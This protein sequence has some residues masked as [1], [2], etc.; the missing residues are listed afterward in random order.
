MM[1]RLEPKNGGDQMIWGNNSVQISHIAGSIIQIAYGANTRLV[2]L[3]PAVVAIGSNVS[4][5]GRVL[6]ARAGVVPYTAHR[7]LLQD[8]VAWCHNG[9]AYAACV[10]GG[11]GGAGKTRLGVEL[12]SRVA[13]ARWL[14]GLLTAAADREELE[15]L[16]RVPTC[17]LVVVDYAET[18]IET[19]ASLLPLLRAH[20]SKEH[21]VRV[22]LLV[23]A[24]PRR[25]D[26][27][28][29]DALRGQ[30]EA[31]EVL[32]DEMYTRV[33]PDE[34]FGTDERS[35]L[36][37]AVVAAL[38]PRL[39]TGKLPDP[40]EGLA[41]PLFCSPLLVAASAYLSLVDPDTWPSTQA[42][43]LEDLIRHE[44]K[45]WSTT[46]P[47][48]PRDP[49]LRRRV[50]A[51]ATLTGAKSQDEA[52]KLLALVPNLGPN[53]S[54][55]RCYELAAWAHSLYPGPAYWNPVEPD[56]LGEHLVASTYEAQPG[57]LAGV[58]G[59][60][61][62]PNLVRPLQV[63]ARLAADR[64]GFAESLAALVNE[65]LP[66]LCRQ[67]I[68]EAGQESDVSVVVGTASLASVVLRL[69]IVVPP[70]PQRLSAVVDL[71]PRRPDLMLGPLAAALTERLVVWRRRLA[72]TNPDAYLPHLATSLNNLSLRLRDVGRREEGL[73]AIREAVEACRA[74][75]EANPAAY[76]PDLARSL[77]NLSVHLGDARRWEE[78]VATSQEAMELYRALAEA[79]PAAYFPDRA[80]AMNNMSVHLGKAG[81]SEEALAAIEEAVELRRSLAE[82]NPAAYLPDLATSLNNLSHRLG[83]VGRRE[84]GLAASQ[85]VME[86]YR[87]LAEA[88]PA[89]YLPD[90]AMSLNN[91]SNNLADV[92]RSEEALAAI[93][94]AVELRRALAE[95]N[96]AAYLPDLA[97]SLNNLSLR[98][99]DAG[100]QEEGVAAIQE[101]IELY[102][103][104]AEANPAAYLPDRAMSLN[105]LSKNLA[106]AGR[107][108]EGVAAIQ[109][110]I[111]LY[112]A[113]AE[114]NPAANFADRAMALN[115]LS[116]HLGNAGRWEEALAAAGEAVE[117]YRALAEANPAAY[118]Y[119]L[120]RSLNNLSVS[121]ADAGRPREAEAVW[122]EA[123]E[124]HAE[125]RR[126]GWFQ[127]S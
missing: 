68:V 13:K 115:N 63:Y 59:D 52:A 2:P 8:L 12:C 20:A 72:E 19:I 108:E 123:M 102:R 34:P 103:A 17:R 45:Y 43:L 47:N 10:L 62:G 42:E 117:A 35:R 104:L 100:R 16:V 21:P 11:G 98:L 1:S 30:G 56:V 99:R 109:E 71:F 96:P 60:R 78:G 49:E 53:A 111:E 23:R 64:P 50:V 95:A 28:W 25:G 29:T 85:E 40:P 82:A 81:R 92:G 37:A 41:G 107:Q 89:A 126:R 31:L 36:F 9:E 125:C 39:G 91:L 90:R 26:G 48:V 79:N 73:A 110:A 80:M 55:E 113:L 27:D 66:E 116:V 105:N 119:D 118:L 69:T 122:D 83:E 97:T 54:R 77:N 44:D 101:A 120:V 94:E 24:A 33:L 4:T 121:L 84:E 75:A 106:D 61:S 6:R 5:P 70:D 3:E 114:A 7:G 112:R 14:A 87:A 57:V 15:A 74:L 127:A 65:Q 88:N 51:L 18:R 86:L 93:E 58:L 124:A 22:L 32:A 46:G 76:L 67:A 38:A